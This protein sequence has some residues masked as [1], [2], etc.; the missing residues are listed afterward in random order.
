[1]D[2]FNPN[3]TDM[4]KSKEILAELKSSKDY[5]SM[6]EI[7]NEQLGTDTEHGQFSDRKQLVYK[8]WTQETT[9]GFTTRRDNLNVAMI[10]E[11]LLAESGHYTQRE[12]N[13]QFLTIKVQS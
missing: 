1:M 4:P 11:P 7:I 5:K 12:V 3:Q 9:R 13:S 2:I 10:D 6:D 8:V